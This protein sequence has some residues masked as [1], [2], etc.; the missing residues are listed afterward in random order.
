[1]LIMIA[2][3]A[4]V[5]CSDLETY[6]EIPRVEFIKV[7]I[8]DTVDDLDN[9]VKQ[10]DITIQVIDGD[11]NLGLN[12]GE[13]TSADSTNLFVTVFNKTADGK[14]EAIEDIKH[15]NYRIPYKQPIGQN[16]YLKAEVIIYMMIA[17]KFI[18][19]D[20]IR[21]GIYVNDRD[22]N[23]SDTTFSCDI[24]IKRNGTIWA[25]GRTDFTD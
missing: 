17:K 18:N 4:A 9:K 6:S 22:M 23:V 5:S 13:T 1:M 16:K 8:A 11:G 12:R 21:Y 2:A 10:Q 24:P 7:F 14:Y 20:T 15:T 3:I 19:Y 25:D